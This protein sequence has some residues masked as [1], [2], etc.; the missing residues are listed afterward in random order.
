MES[1]WLELPD[2]PDINTVLL[3]EEF[4]FMS[5]YKKDCYQALKDQLTSWE[6]IF[7]L[8]LPKDPLTAP[9]PQD[10]CVF[11]LGAYVL[12]SRDGGFKWTKYYIRTE[13]GIVGIY[14]NLEKSVCFYCSC[15]H[16]LRTTTILSVQRR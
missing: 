16:N 2:E 5:N 9:D 13:N 14:E 7:F 11:E 15:T 8:P 6:T 10:I 4:A 12:M 1:Q 3:Y